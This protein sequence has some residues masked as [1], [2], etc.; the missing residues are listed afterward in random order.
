MFIYLTNC[1]NII[2]FFVV[3]FC[4]GCTQASPSAFNLKKARCNRVGFS[5]KILEFWVPF[6]SNSHH[7]FP[8]KSHQGLNLGHHVRRL[9]ARTLGPLRQLANQTPTTTFPVTWAPQWR[10][11]VS[12]PFAL[13]PHRTHHYIGGYCC[14]MC[15][16]WQRENYRKRLPTALGAR[17][18]MCRKWRVAGYRKSGFDAA[19]PLWV[20]GG[21]PQEAQIQGA[22]KGNVTAAF[23]SSLCLRRLVDVKKCWPKPTRTL[24]G[25][26]WIHL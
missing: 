4:A 5:L 17:G 2:W 18:G 25:G 11:P 13:S 6:Y 9:V 23:F 3:C 24:Q 1:P 21:G 14:L 7:P 19:G 22:Q 26:P 8:T 10:F 15:E 12:D 20:V 16:K